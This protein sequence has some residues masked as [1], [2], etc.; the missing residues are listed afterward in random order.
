M[1]DAELCLRSKTTLVDFCLRI[2]VWVR[3]HRPRV[4]VF[5]VGHDE[6]ERD[7]Q[8]NFLDECR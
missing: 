1:Y 6:G 5:I 2:R 3:H 4:S 8:V 7:E